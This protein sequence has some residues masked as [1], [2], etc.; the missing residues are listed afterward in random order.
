MRA[1]VLLDARLWRMN[2]RLLMLHLPVNDMTARPVRQDARGLDQGRK[3][4]A[5]R[6]GRTAMTEWRLASAASEP[7]ADIQGRRP[8][9]GALAH[10]PVLILRRWFLFSRKANYL[11]STCGHNAAGIKLWRGQVSF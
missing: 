11:H 6:H 10:Q 4:P 8:P 2:L 1:L 9:L 5:C 7:W 3:I